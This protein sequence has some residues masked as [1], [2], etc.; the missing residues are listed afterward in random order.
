MSQP[1]SNSERNFCKFFESLSG[2]YIVLLPDSRLTIVAMTESFNVMMNTKKNEILDQGFFEVFAGYNKELLG[3]FNNVILNKITDKINIPKYNRI[4]KKINNI[5]SNSNSVEEEPICCVVNS[6]I[7]DDNGK[8]QFLIHRLEDLTDFFNFQLDGKQK[9][10]IEMP[11]FNETSTKEMAAELQLHSEK[12]KSEIVLKD[13]ALQYANEKLRMSQEL[14]RTLVEGLIDCF[15][16]NSYPQFEKQKDRILIVEDDEEMRQALVDLLEPFYIVDT[17]ANG[18]EGLE[19]SIE[20][21]PNLILCELLLSKMSGTEM[22]R[23]IRNHPDLEKTLFILLTPEADDVLRLQL[24]RKGI[25]DYIV[26]PFQCED[27]L[28]RIQ[29]LLAI[30]KIQDLNTIDGVLENALDCVIGINCWGNI[31]HWNSQAENTFGWTKEEVLGRKMSEVIIPPSYRLLHERSFL[32][33]LKSGHSK[34]INKRLELKGLRKDNSEFPIELSVTPIR[35]KDSFVFYGFIRDITDR[36]K[37]IEELKK[38]KEQAEAANNA[39]SNFLANMSHEIRTP[40]AAI[41]GF[42]ELL[43]DPTISDENKAHFNQAIKRNG[44]LLVNLINEILDLSKVESGKLNVEFSDCLLYEL[45]NDVLS[46]FNLKVSEKGIQLK[47]HYG[48]GIPKVIHTDPVRLKQILLNIVGNAVKFTNHGNVEVSV[49]K[50]LTSEGQMR[51]SFN[52]K[53]TGIGISAEDRGKLFQPFSQIDNSSTRLF[54]G[55]GLGLALS[56]RF[57]HLLGG[58]IQLIDSVKGQG[59][60]FLVTI[61]PGMNS[62]QDETFISANFPRSGFQYPL[63]YPHSNA[64]SQALSIANTPAP[65]ADVRRIDGVR[66]LLAEDSIDNQFL[67]SQILKKAGAVVE[68]AENGKVALEKAHQRDFDIF[69]IDIQMPVMDGYTTVAELRREGFKSPVI[70]LTANALQGDRERSLFSGFNEHIS[71]PVNRTSLVNTVYNY[72]EKH[73]DPI[74]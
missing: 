43:T 12:M 25:Q 23:N 72:C 24:F 18:E 39:K 67:I 9:S 62:V 54:G 48:P 41:L 46:A 11:K 1:D 2:Q 58:D 47:A 52:I 7:L 21:K 38:A 66:V 20:L 5:E 50:S 53:D 35:T 8:V 6:P 31:T 55:T 22:L 33:F 57:A 4:N 56:K 73:S 42:T 27:I 26:K 3:S 64:Y 40:L 51:L 19:K 60:T 32:K 65:V 69:L 45:M 30:R 10:E 71:K 70:A 63:S 14:S 74:V 28:A 37:A 29:N 68:I 49:E 34:N 44:E 61:D 13:K 17:A 36:V 15:K 16:P 59:S